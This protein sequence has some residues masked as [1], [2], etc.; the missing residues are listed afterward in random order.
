RTIGRR[1]L[2][3]GH[4]GGLHA[5][6]PASFEWHGEGFIPVQPRDLPDAVLLAISGLVRADL[7]TRIFLELAQQH[8]RAP[9]GTGGQAVGRKRD[10]RLQLRMLA[11]L[12][13]PQ[14]ALAVAD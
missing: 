10:Y 6:L 12:P 14:A 13:G 1:N 11:Q 3:V 7:P 5:S 9:P 4:I 2:A 8:E